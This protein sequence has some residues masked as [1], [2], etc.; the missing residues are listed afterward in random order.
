MNPSAQAF[1]DHGYGLKPEDFAPF[2]EAHLRDL[3]VA[4][5][6]APVKRRAEVLSRHEVGAQLMG[7]ITDTDAAATLILELWGPEEPLADA[8]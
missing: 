1:D 2:P 4:L 7:K 6:E 5:D 3:A 8:A